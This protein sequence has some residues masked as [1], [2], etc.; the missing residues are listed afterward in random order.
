MHRKSYLLVEFDGKLRSFL[1]A[2][3]ELQTE[4]QPGWYDGGRHQKISEA[5]KNWRRFKTHDET[6]LA[7]AM[8]KHCGM[9]EEVPVVHP[10]RR[11]EANRIIDE[12]N[13]P[14]LVDYRGGKPCET[15]TS[16]MNEHGE[17]INAD[18][19]STRL[20][21][22]HG[23]AYP[24]PPEGQQRYRVMVGLT[25][26][27]SYCDYHRMWMSADPRDAALQVMAYLDT[28]EGSGPFGFKS[29]RVVQS[30]VTNI[31]TEETYF[32]VGPNCD[33]SA[34]SKAL[35]AMFNRLISGADDFDFAL[36]DIGL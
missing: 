21:D 28:P 26:G 17:P 34:E 32:Y 22:N 35:G 29:D 27:A 3:G 6:T 11:L 24:S 7:K 20:C 31:D 23:V 15:I 13:E 12:N 10:D 4:Y 16:R 18:G 25:A 1:F 19:I 14:Y 30:I 8:L 5:F 33:E 36:G 2:D 9:F